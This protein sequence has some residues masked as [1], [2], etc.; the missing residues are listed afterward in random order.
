MQILTLILIFLIPIILSIG[1]VILERNETESSI[2]WVIAS[3]ITFLISCITCY[4]Y[5]KHFNFYL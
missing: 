1:S 4:I 5:V 3:T 2:A